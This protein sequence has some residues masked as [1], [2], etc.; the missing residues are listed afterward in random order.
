MRPA[1]VS[2]ISAS[3]ICVVTRIA[4]TPRR[5]P[6][7][8]LPEPAADFSA[9][10]GLND[11]AW[12]AGANETRSAVSIETTAVNSSVAASRP[13]IDAPILVRPAARIAVQAA[14]AVRQNADDGERD[15]VDAKAPA[16][17][18]RVG[19]KPARPEPVADH[20]DGAGTL[21]VGLFVGERAAG[22]RRDPEDRR[23]SIGDNLSTQAQRIAVSRQIEVACGEQREIAVDVLQI[24]ER[25]V[26]R[27]RPDHLRAAHARR[28]LLRKREVDEH[29]RVRIRERQ[30]LEEDRIDHGEH[31][32]VGA[33]A[34]SQR[35]ERDGGESWRVNE[36]AKGITNITRESGHGAISFRWRLEGWRTARCRAMPRCVNHDA[37]GLR[38]QPA[39]GCRRPVGPLD[40]V[41]LLERV[42]EHPFARRRRRGATDQPQQTPRDH[43]RALR[44]CST[45]ASIP[46]NE[47]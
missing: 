34:E 30:P 31:G 6:P 24:R 37:P 21:A 45:P 4:R 32:G 1:P 28:L 40:V 25:A 5:R 11:E 23:I 16:D 38:A 13:I 20:R 14:E 17:D 12:S 42:A 2:S 18:R 46:V 26:L 47:V 15:G 8:S 27:V 10:I 19:A 7:A 41:E 29:Q 35:E 43:Y 36:H 44:R 9:S 3:A 22:C 33:N 39:P